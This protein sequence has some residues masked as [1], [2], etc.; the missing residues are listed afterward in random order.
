[1]IKKSFSVYDMTVIVISLLSYLLDIISDIFIIVVFYLDGH[2]VW[3]SLSLAFLALSSVSMLLFSF[4]WHITDKTL[5]WKN[6]L[7]HV[8]FLAPLHRYIEV[9]RL[10]YISRKTKQKDDLDAALRA[11]VDVSLLRLIE[12]FTESAP[13]LVLQ[14]YIMLKF[15]HYNWLIGVSTVLSLTSVAFSLTSYSDALKMAYK[16][17]HKRSWLGVTILTVW[18]SWMLLSRVTALVVFSLVF[19]AWVFLGMG[20]HWIFMTFWIT[21]QNAEY[22]DTACEK[23]LFNSISGFIYIFCFLN[24]KEGPSKSRMAAFYCFILAENALMML[25]WF[26]YKPENTPAWLEITSLSLVFGGFVL[27]GILMIGYYCCC[28][29]TGRTAETKKDLTAYWFKRANSLP[30]RNRDPIFPMNNSVARVAD[31]LNASI[32]LSTTETSRYSNLDNMSLNLSLPDILKNGTYFSKTDTPDSSKNLNNS[33]YSFS[34]RSRNRN[35]DWNGTVTSTKSSYLSTS[36][37]R[38][39]INYSPPSVSYISNSKDTFSFS[40]Q[41][42]LDPERSA[43]VASLSNSERAFALTGQNSKSSQHEVSGVSNDDDSFYASPEYKASACD[44]SPLDPKKLWDESQN[45]LNNTANQIIQ[46]ITTTN[47]KRRTSES[48]VTW[49]KLDTGVN[50]SNDVRQKYDNFLN[51]ENKHCD[52]LQPIAHEYYE[53]NYQNDYSGTGS[54]LQSSDEDLLESSN[55]ENMTPNDKSRRSSHQSSRE[56]SSLDYGTSALSNF[57]GDI[58]SFHVNSPEVGEYYMSSASQSKLNSIEED[59]SDDYNNSLRSWSK[60]M[61]TRIQKQLHDGTSSTEYHTSDT[62]PSLTSSYVQEENTRSI[63]SYGTSLSSNQTSQSRLES[64]SSNFPEMSS[65]YIHDSSELRSRMSTSDIGETSGSMSSGHNY[66]RYSSTTDKSTD[67]GYSVA[68]SQ[69]LKCLN[70][71]KL[72]NSLTFVTKLGSDNEFSTKLGSDGDFP[73]TFNRTNSHKQLENDALDD[74]I[75]SNMKNAKSLPGLSYLLSE[76]DTTSWY[77]DKSVINKTPSHNEENTSFEDITLADESVKEDHKSVRFEDQTP[78]KN[79]QRSN[80][81]PVK[82][83]VMNN[84][85]FRPGKI[86]R[87]DLTPVKL[88]KF[89]NS[90]FRPGKSLLKKSSLSKPLHRSSKDSSLSVSEFDDSPQRLGRSIDLFDRERYRNSVADMTDDVFAKSS[91]TEVRELENSPYKFRSKDTSDYKESKENVYSLGSWR[92][93]SSTTSQH[94]YSSEPKSKD[95]SRYLSEVETTNKTYNVQK[96]DSFTNIK[97]RTIVDDFKKKHVPRNTQKK[98]PAYT[99]DLS[100]YQSEAVTNPCYA[101]SDT[102]SEAEISRRS[103]KGPY[104]DE[105]VRRHSSHFHTPV[106]NEGKRQVLRRLDNTPGFSPILTPGDREI[107][108]SS[109]SLNGGSVVKPIVST[110]KINSDFYK[111]GLRYIDE[112]PGTIEV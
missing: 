90:P 7:P 8:V 101:Y 111:E 36:S 56:F 33:R 37:S 12:A 84:S 64:S 112:S 53:N 52:N 41:V 21:M 44:L 27:G 93:Q 96:N 11:N 45:R 14:L 102:E 55:K 24:L 110:P 75:S 6:F 39:L 48:Q 30:D 104:K 89:S 57:F 51:T 71:E 50:D 87:E 62:T 46:I 108:Q 72:Q 61:L 20:I 97:P 73:D 74:K 40:N 106:Q 78:V 76:S 47:L 107:I 35:L 82:V 67:S 3:G 5:T 77:S 79:L 18:Q 60:K 9:L 49:R 29:P 58:S 80:L 1:M 15:S 10:G 103:S 70:G 13:Q 81:T 66:K 91:D 19:Q 86:I 38:P 109:E 99:N 98:A 28:H 43:S 85:P 59:G 88:E 23:R 4:R 54:S 68:K 42:L 65:S 34:R 63:N 2:Y 26:I 95:G 83:A 32:S 94:N 25:L 69:S 92:H 16:E 31:W 17:H 105:R 22:G 100:L